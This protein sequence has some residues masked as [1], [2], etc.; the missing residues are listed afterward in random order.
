[1]AVT[2]EPIA[3]T[4]LGSTA[5]SITLSAIASSWTDLEIVVNGTISVNGAEIGLRFNGSSS[6]YSATRLRG[7][8]STASSMRDTS[9]TYIPLTINPPN[10]LPTFC[11][12]MV[13]S[14]AGGTN[15]TTLIE[16]SE[17]RN[18]SPTSFVGKGVGL[19]ANTSAITSIT[20]MNNS[21]GTFSA[22][23]I[24]TIYGIKEA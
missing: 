17:D 7:N 10:A 13:F 5:S 4:T 23:T 15:K 19:W 11:R 3:T 6:G 1:M 12:A 21:G 20:I 18:G 24:V 9:Y 2:Y 16:G 22:G 8:G 14:Y